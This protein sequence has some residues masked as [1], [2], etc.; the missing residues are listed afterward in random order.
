MDD[1]EIAFT[2]IPSGLG[3]RKWVGIDCICRQDVA[4]QTCILDFGDAI[5]PLLILEKIDSDAS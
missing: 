5:K 1:K 4:L 3:D 2:L